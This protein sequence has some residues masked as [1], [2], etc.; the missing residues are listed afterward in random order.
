MHARLMDSA[1]KEANFESTINFGKECLQA[2]HFLPCMGEVG[3]SI[4]VLSFPFALLRYL[5][6]LG[7]ATNDLDGHGDP[8][9]LSPN[10]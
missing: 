5:K 8:F 9:K 4:R 1:T 6:F 10:H 3:R 7:N 2:T